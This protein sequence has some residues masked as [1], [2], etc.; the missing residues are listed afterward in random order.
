MGGRGREVKGFLTL[1]FAGRGRGGKGEDSSSSF[2]PLAGR[3]EKKRS[4][5]SLPRYRAQ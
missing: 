4:K 5:S 2:I 3:G 1:F